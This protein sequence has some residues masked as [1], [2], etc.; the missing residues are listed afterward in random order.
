[1]NYSQSPLVSTLFTYKDC[2]A[3]GSYN[4]SCS[5]YDCIL[6]QKVGNHNIGDKIGVILVEAGYI[7]I[8]NTAADEITDISR[9]NC[10]TFET[11]PI[12]AVG[13]QIQ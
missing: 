13:R 5:Y 1:M 8:W 9:E 3:W 11:K 4:S 10:E 7:H 2:R 12:L 6:K